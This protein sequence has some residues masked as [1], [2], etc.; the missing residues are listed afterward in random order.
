MDGLTRT[1]PSCNVTS[2]VQDGCL[3]WGSRVIVPENGREAIISL[4]HEGHPGVTHMQWL[5]CGYVWWPG[6]DNELNFAIKTYA[7]CQENQRVLARAPMHPWEWPDRLWATIHI[8]YAGLVKGKVVLVIVDSHSKWIEAHE[9]NSVTS[10]ATVK[11]LQLVFTIHSFPEVIVSDNGTSFTS[12]EFTA[13]IRSNGIKHLTIAQC[14]PTSNKL[15]ERAVQTLKN[16]LKKDPGGV[17]LATHI[18]HFLFW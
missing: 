9:V 14:H 2:S 15:A 7:E 5:A 6:I 11:K 8:D 3:L 18:S 1:N 13:F 12:E 16:A 17:S 4:L 10:Q